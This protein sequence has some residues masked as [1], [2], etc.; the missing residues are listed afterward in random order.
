MDEFEMKRRIY[1]YIKE[2]CHYSQMQV[3]ATSYYQKNYF[4]MQID[5]A[6]GA[7]ISLYTDLWKSPEHQIRSHSYHDQENDTQSYEQM[8]IQN[9]SPF[10]EQLLPQTEQQSTPQEQPVPAPESSVEPEQRSFTVEELAYYDGSNG[11]P[12]YVAVDGI[13]YNVSE[14]ARWAGG[15]HF[16]LRA[17]KD[18]SSQFKGCHLGIMDRLNRLP[19]VGIVVEGV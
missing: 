10:Q 16:G 5:D 14:V 1:G 11:K 6:T 17:G 15:R 2:M 3:F 12:A 8:A 18:Q 13:V 4:Q 19:K 7:L 9:Q